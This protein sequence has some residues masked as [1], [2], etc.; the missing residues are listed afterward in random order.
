MVRLQHTSGGVRT[1]HHQNSAFYRWARTHYIEQTPDEMRAAIYGFLDH[2]QRKTDK[3]ELV[4]F[5]PNR[6]KV[7][8]V[9]EALAAA[10]QL[11]SGTQP[12]AWLDGG[13]HPPASE[14]VACSN[15]LLHLPA[16]KLLPQTP[17][18]FSMNALDFAY[19]PAAR[20]PAAWLKFLADLWPGDQQ[21]IDA[22]QEF[23]G[24]ALT[25]DTSHQK[26]LLIVGPKRSGKGT[27]AR[28]LTALLGQANVSGPTLSRMSKNF[29][30]APLI[31]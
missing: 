9:L 19:D 24:L 20:Q 16:R 28:V 30:L 25:A 5:N 2:A 23:F 13:N 1:L 12:P 7:L 10:T 26:A 31:G 3:D 17:S 22:L 27:V 29:G 18:F 4:P 11:S 21:S 8:N 6:A 14:I 15:G